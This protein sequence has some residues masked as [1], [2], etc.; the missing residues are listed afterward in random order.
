MKLL[1]FHRKI[2]PLSSRNQ[3]SNRDVGPL[4]ETCFQTA[5]RLVEKKNER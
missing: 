2:S 1:S 4:D 3:P 5:R